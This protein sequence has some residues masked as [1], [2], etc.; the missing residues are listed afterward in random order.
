MFSELKT[1]PRGLSR[2]EADR[3]LREFG[4]NE[5]IVGRKLS[6]FRLFLKQFRSPFVYILIIATLIA[7]VTGELIVA[8][9]ILIIVVVNATL[10]FF[11]ERKSNKAL[12]KLRKYNKYNAKVIREGK[13]IIMDGCWELLR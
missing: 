1:T 6:S 3:R 12:E 13:K 5:V 8:I 7:G 9:I 10:G 11:L 4:L 2:E